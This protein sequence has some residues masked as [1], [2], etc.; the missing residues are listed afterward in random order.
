MSILECID[1][2]RSTCHRVFTPGECLTLLS[3]ANGEI[4]RE[5]WVAETLPIWDDDFQKVQR[6]NVQA[7]GK[8]WVYLTRDWREV[9]R[10]SEE[11]LRRVVS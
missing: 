11:E 1:H 9:T 2:I 6:Y 3:P 5:R 7:V 8:G 4:W 10:V